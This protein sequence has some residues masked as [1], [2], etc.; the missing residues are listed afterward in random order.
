MRINASNILFLKIQLTAT[1]VY[2]YIMVTIILH[3]RAKEFQKFL[4]IC[5]NELDF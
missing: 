1:H 5:K 4:Y 2:F 3:L